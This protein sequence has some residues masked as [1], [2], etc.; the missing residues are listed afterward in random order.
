MNERQ[1]TNLGEA[2]KDASDISQLNKLSYIGTEQLLAGI[3]HRSESTVAKFLKEYNVSYF[4]YYEELR[5]L[6]KNEN[7][8]GRPKF[9]DNTEIIFAVSYAV[10]NLC[11]SPVVGT[12]HVFVT[13]LCAGDTVASKILRRLGVPLDEATERMCSGLNISVRSI[14]NLFEEYNEQ[15]KTA[16]GGYKTVKT[17]EKNNRASDDTSSR[18]L[19]SK[20]VY[21]VETK[22]E[23]REKSFDDLSGIEEQNESGELDEFGINLTDLARKGKLD[24][25]IGRDDVI[26]RVI[27]AL[28]R[29]TKNSPVL[30]GEAGVGKSAVVEGLAQAI[31]S[32][33]VPD[34]LIGKEIFS[35]NISDLIAGARYRGE[36][37]ERFKKALNIIKNDD[38]IIL[39]IDEIHNI[40]GT[41]GGK[42]SSG[43]DVA[44][45][46]KPAL[47]RGEFRVIGATTI[48][49][50]RKYIEK[51]PALDRRFQQINVDP[52]STDA[53]KMILRGLR[54]KF[55]DHHRVTITDK[56]IDAAVDLSDR[57]IT[58]R[59]LP[60][61][62]ID[63]IDEAAAHVKI[64]FSSCEAAMTELDKTIKTL[65][66]QRDFFKSLG[67]ID[68]MSDLT[69]DINEKTA[70][71]KRLKTEVSAKKSGKRPTVDREDVAETISTMTDIP[72]SGITAE[73]S[74]KLL[75]LEEELGKRVIGQKQ[76]IRAVSRALKRARADLKDPKRPNGSFIFV[77]PTGVGKTELAKA[78]AEA[79][80][81]DEKA[82][83]RID[84]SEYPEKHDVSKLIGVAPGYVGYEEEGQL[85]GKVR[86][87]PY[88]VVL[89]DEIEKAHPDIFNIFL[90]ILDDGRLTDSKGRLVDFKNT[91]IIM[92]SNVGAKECD[93][94]PIDPE[95]LCGDRDLDVQVKKA[96][97]KKFRP[98]F[99]NRVDEIVAFRKLTEEECGKI[100]ELLLGSLRKRLAKRQIELITDESVDRV[101]L[102]VGYDPEYGARPLRRA[103]QN[104]IE[105]ML[106]D[107]IIAGR[108]VDGDIVKLVGKN[109]AIEY[110]II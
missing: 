26:E 106:S 46:L 50:Y 55:E 68:R 65:Y 92:T 25:V 89:F 64:K 18:G 82:L 30:V 14:R 28:S 32:G 2:V 96:L 15:R 76:A 41:G 80:F 42:E 81:G 75:N 70:E 39:F 90:Q 97:E 110:I 58:D 4:D 37:E 107:E 43:M 20:R 47:A 9:T 79:V 13:M 44:E 53:A 45:M 34:T 3:I 94:S 5:G 51:D 91:I 38:R 86:R 103:I 31:T 101:I 17:N 63:V 69:R 21:E 61:K 98:E 7:F 74:R 29:R 102:D 16:H 22:E 109:D 54:A 78:L 88:S 12:E 72:V 95:D 52:P 60:D 93:F 73:E 99:L 56:A 49:E 77:G 67:E 84:M 10:A 11:K 6:M 48:D 105:D 104:L 83:I 71:L 24:P 59:N 27:T 100:V 23:Y 66:S 1:S 57:Y 33:N 8:V 36:F 87:R 85:T 108:I 35:L 40:V 19:K 62:A